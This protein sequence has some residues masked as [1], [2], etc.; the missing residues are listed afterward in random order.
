MIR[1]KT[2]Q[3]EQLP[4]VEL[5]SLFPGLANWPEELQVEPVILA[6]AQSRHKTSISPQL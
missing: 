1:C 4:L 2:G 5:Y 3:V 6:T